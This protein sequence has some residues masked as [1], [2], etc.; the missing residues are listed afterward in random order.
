MKPNDPMLLTDG[1]LRYRMYPTGKTAI[2][3]HLATPRFP[4]P[5]NFNVQYQTAFIL[6][7]FPAS[8]ETLIQKNQ[9]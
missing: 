6:D 3:R 2:S 7:T 1:I 9:E 8:D 4:N 5:M